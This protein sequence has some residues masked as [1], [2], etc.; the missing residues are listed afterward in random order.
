MLRKKHA[1]FMADCHCQQFSFCAAMHLVFQTSMSE[2][3]TVEEKNKFQAMFFLS[4]LRL[5]GWERRSEGF[6]IPV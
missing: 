2:P 1:P 4:G 6:K 3:A 5:G